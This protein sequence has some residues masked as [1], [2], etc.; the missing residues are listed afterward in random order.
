MTS[1]TPKK[2]SH[3]ATS[4]LKR[5]QGSRSAVPRNRESPAPPPLGLEVQQV[6]ALRRLRQSPHWPHYQ[7][8][9]ETVTLNN[10]EQLLH[11][12]PHDQY[13]FYCGAVF[14]CR[15]LMELP[16]AILAK[17]HDLEDHA[18][19]R[20]ESQAAHERARADTFLNTP[21]WQSYVEDTDGRKFADAVSAAARADSAAATRS[22]T[23]LG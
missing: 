15:R 12:L 14:A 20:T 9:L 3:W 19:A 7:Q 4:L 2:F 11:A 17:V 21:F 16:D 13:L 5:W 8:L 23:D 1:A 22:L 18:N 10:V 6:E